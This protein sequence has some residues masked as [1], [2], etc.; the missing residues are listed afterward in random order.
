MKFEPNVLWAKKSRVAVSTRA[1]CESRNLLRDQAV[2]CGPRKRIPGGFVDVASTAERVREKLQPSV[3]V[4]AVILLHDECFIRSDPRK[5]DRRIGD[6]NN[7]RG[8]A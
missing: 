2:E 3:R 8:P 7:Q 5:G 1:I 6:A 4:E